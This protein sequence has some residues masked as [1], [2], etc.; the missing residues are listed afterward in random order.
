[1]LAPLVAVVGVAHRRDD[2]TGV[3]DAPIVPLF[4]LG[5]L[6]AI[7]LRA[8]PW[9]SPSQL[10]IGR[11]LENVT[12]TAGMFALGAGVEIVRLRRLGGK[13]LVLG[14]ASWALVALLALGAAYAGT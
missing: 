12:L 14:F 7:G 1:M 10:E 2:G 11:Q 3:A 4:V 9:L 13:P 6:A 8:T 5:F